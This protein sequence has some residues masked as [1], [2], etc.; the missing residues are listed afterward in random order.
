MGTR[1]KGNYSFNNQRDNKRTRRF[2]F[3]GVLLML[4][5]CVMSTQIFAWRV[6]K[7]QMPGELFSYAK[8]RVYA[9]WKLSPD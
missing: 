5:S 6:G 1:V 8:I 3:A 7:N 2:A 4:L 9:P